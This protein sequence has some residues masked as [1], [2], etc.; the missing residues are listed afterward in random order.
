MFKTT[1]RI[2]IATCVLL[3]SVGSFGACSGESD[4]TNDDSN[5]RGGR[6]TGNGGT[7]TTGSLDVSIQED[8][9]GGTDTAM[10]N[11][12][13]TG[14]I[15]CSALP[16]GTNLGSVCADAATCGDGGVCAGTGEGDT[17]CYQVCLPENCEDVCATGETCVPLTDPDGQP[18]TLEDGTVIG[19]CVV[20]PTGDTD[21]YAVCNA[22]NLCQSG[23]DC[24]VTEAGATDG[25][26]FPNCE[27]TG[28]CPV[29]N[30][31]QGFCAVTTS[32]EPDAQPTHCLPSC[33]DTAASSDC[34]NG[35]ICQA[36]GQGV[37][38]CAPQQ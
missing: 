18:Q 31:A 6:D 17:V 20:P 4:E 13:N 34:P 38:L 21:A 1:F 10:G 7:D 22:E 2:L 8:T 28:T 23:M 16:V 15:D 3:L 14:G 33:T 25:I 32:T 26:C 5:P 27:G 37:N 30:G 29:S 11:D 9:G 24:L 35:W 36:A 19:A 12:T